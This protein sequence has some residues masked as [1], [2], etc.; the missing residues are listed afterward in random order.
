MQAA[1]KGVSPLLR[2]MPGAQTE[3]SEGVPPQE[4]YLAAL[5]TAQPVPSVTII[6]A[7]ERVSQGSEASRANARHIDEA[8]V[9]RLRRRELEPR[10]LSAQAHLVLRPLVVS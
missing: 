3:G 6:G 10:E 5:L 8:Q 7:C 9:L 1:A 4:M 2:E